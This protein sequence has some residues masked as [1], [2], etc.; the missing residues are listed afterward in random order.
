MKAAQQTDQPK[1]VITVKVGNEYVIDAREFGL[2]S[3]QLL[4]GTF[5]TIYQEIVLPHFQKLGG[6]VTVGGRCSAGRT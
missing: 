1:E 3:T 5:P 6:R 4:L 2:R